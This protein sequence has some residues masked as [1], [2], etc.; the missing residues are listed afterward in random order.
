SL[1]AVTQLF[2]NGHRAIRSRLPETGYFTYEKGLD[3]RTHLAY[4]GFIYR[5]NQFN[6]ITLS[7]TSITEFIIYHSLTTSRHY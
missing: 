6:N 5:E 7:S 1:P 3:N 4:Q 2:V